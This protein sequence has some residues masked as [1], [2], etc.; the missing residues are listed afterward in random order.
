MR[1]AI[2]VRQT[3]D[4]YVCSGQVT[5]LLRDVLGLAQPPTQINIRVKVL[6][7]LVHVV[8]NNSIR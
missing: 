5:R 1:C 6:K 8:S 2:L 7:Q 3:P 4:V